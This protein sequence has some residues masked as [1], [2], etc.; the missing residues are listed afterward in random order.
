MNTWQSIFNF[1]TV[2]VYL[3]L[4]FLPSFADQNNPK[5]GAILRVQNQTQTKTVESYIN[6]LARRDVYIKNKT[7]HN[8]CEDDPLQKRD[9]LNIFLLI[10]KILFILTIFLV[11]VQPLH[12]H[13]KLCL[14]LCVFAFIFAC[15]ILGIC[16]Y[17]KFGTE[18]L[19][20]VNYFYIF[21][22]ALFLH[23]LQIIFAAR[24]ITAYNLAAAG[25]DTDML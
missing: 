8:Y 2:T 6:V 15:A 13:P 11:C 22:F 16:L 10:L 25:L 7:S 1:F 23:C 24:S 4:L 5:I 21:V 9:N 14:T 3:V 12:M 18:K 20:I 17:L 19:K